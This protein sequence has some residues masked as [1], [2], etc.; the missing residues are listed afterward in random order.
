MINKIPKNNINKKKEIFT[1]KN[2]G[3]TPNYL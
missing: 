3:K 1:H 2:Y